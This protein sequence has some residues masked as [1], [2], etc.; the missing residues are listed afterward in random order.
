MATDSV[1]DIRKRRMKRV[2]SVPLQRTSGVGDEVS[3]D[4]GAESGGSGPPRISSAAPAR[5]EEV[6]T[7]ESAATC[8]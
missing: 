1:S 8:P 5:Q 2:S 6:S 3:D 7:P 4:E